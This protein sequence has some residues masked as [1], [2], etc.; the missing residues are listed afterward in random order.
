MYTQL[1]L[2]SLVF[3][4]LQTW[5]GLDEYL[6]NIAPV[7]AEELNNLFIQQI[8][9]IKLALRESGSSDEIT[10]DN[11]VKIANDIFNMRD[12]FLLK[13][14]ERVPIDI[15]D[16]NTPFKVLEKREISNYISSSNFW[17]NE[18]VIYALCS[19]LK[20][21]I[22]PLE[23]IKVSDRKSILRVPYAN[24]SPDLNNWNKYLFLYYYQSHYELITFN[25][26]TNL[27]KT[28][29]QKINTNIR[30]QPKK[31]SKKSKII[32]DR[33][34]QISQLPPIYI[35]FVIYGSYFSNIINQQDKLNFTFKKE[36]MLTID[37]II[38][39]NLYNT[40]AYNSF[41]YPVFKVFFPN[42]NIRNPANPIEPSQ[43]R[44]IEES[45]EG[46]DPYRGGA[47]P[48][49]NPYNR[50]PYN[51]PAYYN[52]Q[53]MAHNMEKKTM[54]KDDSQLAYLVTIDMEL[55]PGKSLSP[56]ELTNAKCNSKWN[57]IRKSYADLVGKPYLIPPIYNKTIKNKEET[58][59]T[60]NLRPDPQNNTRKNIKG[61]KHNRTVKNK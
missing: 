42:G 47:Y 54:D 8:N 11:Y 57:S 40:P 60:Q 18:I 1:Y 16:Y 34:E 41:F 31:F 29:L 23:S 39:N 22:I 10:P 25:Q 12:N 17:A 19:E 9:G 6:L 33:N 30:V 15:D 21:N 26:K 49:Y 44:A 50:N 46:G 52:P 3:K 7:N 27:Q 45:S 35:L 5:N 53:Y 43:M 2:R 36:I 14:V 58:N 55:R 24:F 56:T 51:R 37:N 13:N 32:F 61:G 20:L 38:N 48:N 59:K 28:G 4:Y